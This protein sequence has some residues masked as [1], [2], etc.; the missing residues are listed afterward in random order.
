M[1]HGKI[2]DL[3][4]LT[5]T[6]AQWEQI[7]WRL[8]QRAKDDSEEMKGKTRYQI[9]RDGL[10]RGDRASEQLLAE[11][12]D[13]ERREVPQPCGECNAEASAYWTTD[14]ATGEIVE[15]YCSDCWN[16]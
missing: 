11:L 14:P 9:Q 8:H 3:V 5:M 12:R 16:N 13:A 2:D 15:G 7:Q 4:T 10:S 1:E 6:P